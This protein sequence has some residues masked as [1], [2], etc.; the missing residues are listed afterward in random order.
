MT[1]KGQAGPSQ[2]LPDLAWASL[3]SW[4]RETLGP[5]GRGL[6][7]FLLLQPFNPQML[8]QHEA[9]AT[10][11]LNGEPLVLLQNGVRG[12]SYKAGRRLPESFFFPLKAS[13]SFL[14]GSK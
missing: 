7:L 8:L 2:E 1:S 10:G 12:R 3:F 5:R 9:V 14:S 13:L 4:L 6:L 11:P